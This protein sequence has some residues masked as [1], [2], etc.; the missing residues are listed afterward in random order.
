MLDSLKNGMISLW[1]NNA[2]LAKGQNTMD[3]VKTKP[4]Q[5]TTL[6]SWDTTLDAI[7]VKL[8]NGH[9]EVNIGEITIVMSAK[10][11]EALELVKKFGEVEVETKTTGKIR[12]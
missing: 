2:H 10:D 8:T 1:G 9:L 7:S 3:T 6:Y 4:R 11:C 5:S 12:V